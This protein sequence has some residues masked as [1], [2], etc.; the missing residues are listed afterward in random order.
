MVMIDAWRPGDGER[1]QTHATL[2]VLDLQEG[3]QVVLVEPIFPQ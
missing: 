2:V 1:T 3:G